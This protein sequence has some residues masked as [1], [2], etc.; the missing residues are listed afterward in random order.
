M[1]STV[2]AARPSTPNNKIKQGAGENI[3]TFFIYLV[4]FLF[5][6]MCILPFILVVIVSLS[7]EKS[8]TLN[9]Y[10]F[11]PSEWSTAAYEMLFL[12]SSAVPPVS[13]THLDVYKR[14]ILFS[15]DAF[16]SFG[17]LNGAIFADMGVRLDVEREELL[18]HS[19][20]LRVTDNLHL[21]RCV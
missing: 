4:V 8:I 18:D 14:Q 12:P 3:G 5:A 15:A 11:W 2:M 21:R 19:D 9:G 16:G 20:D 10:S 1:N 7:S 17:A 6:V 13:Y